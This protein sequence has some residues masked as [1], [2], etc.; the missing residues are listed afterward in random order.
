MLSSIYIKDIIIRI[1]EI[2]VNTPLYYLCPNK[3]VLI[4]ANMNLYYK[5]IRHFNLGDDL[6]YFL[7]NELSEKKVMNYKGILHFKQTNY[8]CIGSIIEWNSNKYSIVWGSGAIAGGN[9]KMRGVP[10]NIKAVRGPLS[11]TF[12]MSKGIDCPAIYGDPALLLPLVYKPSLPKIYKYGF[13]PHYVDLN[14]KNI[15]EFVKNRKDCCIIDFQK[16][17]DWHDTID[18]INQC[19]M[20]ISSSL[21]GIIISDAYNIPN[22]WVKYS[23]NIYGGNFKYLDYFASVRR[24]QTQPIIIDNIIDEGILVEASR[25]WSPI[26]IDL[27]ILLNVCPFELKKKYKKIQ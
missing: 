24:K 5:R 16:Y 25:I 2:L 12:L 8:M 6:N 10:M 1:G 11:R 21:H 4:N 20:I 13:I 26:D 15:I 22:V 17:K 18:M 19:E 3:Y 9:E 27:D 14:N 7:I 23:N